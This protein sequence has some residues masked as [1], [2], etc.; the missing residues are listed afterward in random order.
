VETVLTEVGPRLRQLRQARKVTLEALAADSGFT[1]GY[2]SQ[3]EN[4]AA[5]PSLTALGVIA[6]C[7][8]SDLAAFFP[9][10]PRVGVRVTRAGDPDRFRIEPNAR[11]EHS[12]LSGRVHGGTFTANLARHYPGQPVHRFSHVGE[13]WALV[14]S[15]A[16]RFSI[17]GEER[18]VRE[19]EWIHYSSHSSHAAEAITNG[20]SEVLWF[21]SP[22]IF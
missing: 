4:G 16:L 1:T 22:A 8:E 7:L 21:L 9:Q 19:G 12:L 6:A 20:P 18:I 3:I 15:G 11:E 10:E 5:V 14:L 13:E 2:L 17:D